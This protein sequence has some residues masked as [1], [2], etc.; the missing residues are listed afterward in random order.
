MTCFAVG[1][2]WILLGWVMRNCNMIW[3]FLYLSRAFQVRASRV[4][5]SFVIQS[6]SPPC[7]YLHLGSEIPSAFHLNLFPVVLG[8]FGWQIGRCLIGNW[9][10][11][12]FEFDSIP[13]PSSLACIAVIIAAIAATYF[14]LWIFLIHVCVFLTWPHF[15]CKMVKLASVI[16]SVVA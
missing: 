8:L 11:H 7:W 13:F 14:R 3:Q 16:L 6:A 9:V 4:G 15:W 2:V 1:N 12:E 5:F 10:T